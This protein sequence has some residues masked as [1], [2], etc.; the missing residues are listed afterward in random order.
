MKITDE[1]DLIDGTM[2]NVYVLKVQDKIVQIDSGMSYNAKKIKSYYE[3]SGRSPSAIFITHYHPDHVGALQKVIEWYKPDLYSSPTEARYLDGSEKL[4]KPKGIAGLVGTLS[5]RLNFGNVK[6]CTTMGITGLECINT[7]GH[8]P[9]STSLL[10]RQKEIVFIGDAARERDRK[11]E[12]VS[13]F[14]LDME[15]AQKSLDR[16]VSLKPVTVL[17]GHGSPVRLE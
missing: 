2:A 7:P 6:D 15:E 4:P 5:K 12:I 3:F 11:L 10:F 14:T 8:T 13:G 16:I 17:P 9:G 1:V